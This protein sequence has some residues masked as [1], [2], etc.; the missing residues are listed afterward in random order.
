MK[1][2]KL[3]IELIGLLDEFEQDRQNESD[4]GLDEFIGFLNARSAS[5]DIEI[6][7]I[8][9]GEEQQMIMDNATAE[10][11]ISRLISLMYRYAKGYIKKA[12]KGS[13]IQTADEFTFIIILMTHSSLSKTE[14]INK[15]IMEK[16]SG[17]EVIKRLIKK[18]LIEQFS[19]D[20]DKR[21]QKV[22]VTLSGR[23]EIFTVLPN[24]NIV[25][26]I[27]AGNLSIT[28]RQTLAYLLK[29]LDYYHNEL[30]ITKRDQELND[31][32]D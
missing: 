11:E 2:K 31:L 22:A 10:I 7:D 18:G 29:K 19:D 13:A 24:M 32:L 28:E 20:N 23:S 9:G 25:S 3:L 21:S 12:L 5:G 16:T 8:T 14:L 17:I 15:N 26:K 27:V 30:Y 1:S 6:R 4:V